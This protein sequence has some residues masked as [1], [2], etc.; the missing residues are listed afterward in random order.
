MGSGHIGLLGTHGVGAHGE[1]HSLSPRLSIFIQCPRLT[2]RGCRMK[3]ESVGLRLVCIPAL[4]MKRAARSASGQS[5]SVTMTP[6]M[7][8]CPRGSLSSILRRWS[9]CSLT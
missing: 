1:I 7:S 2:S 9:R 6:N 4:C 3:L 5:A 8:E